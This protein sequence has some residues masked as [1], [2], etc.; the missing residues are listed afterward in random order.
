MAN[1]SV[2]PV[3]IFGFFG[4]AHRNNNYISA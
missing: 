3:N 2:L 1:E 4:S